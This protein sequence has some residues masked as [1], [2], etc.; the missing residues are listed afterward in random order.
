MTEKEREITDEEKLKADLDKYKPWPELFFISKTQKVKL[1]IY[2]NK[3]DVNRICANLMGDDINPI[4]DSIPSH[5][6]HEVEIELP[7]AAFA[8][9]VRIQDVKK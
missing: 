5:P 9:S 1:T 3:W 6:L 7:F 2:C 8:L 4:D